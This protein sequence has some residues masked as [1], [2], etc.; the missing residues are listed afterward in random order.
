MQS[1]AV[2]IPCR[3]LHHT[4][5]TNPTQLFCFSIIWSIFF[6]TKV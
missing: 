3:T 2:H 5:W 1:V 4:L 6:I